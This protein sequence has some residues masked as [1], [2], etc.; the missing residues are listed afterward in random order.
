M[1]REPYVASV[2]INSCFRLQTQ[3]TGVSSVFSRSACSI[4]NR[5]REHWQDHWQDTTVLTAARIAGAVAV[6]KVLVYRKQIGWL[7]FSLKCHWDQNFG[8]PCFYIF[9]HSLWFLV[10]MPNFNLLRRLEVAFFGRFL[11]R[12]CGR[13]YLPLFRKLACEW[14]EVTSEA[15]LKP[16]AFTWLLPTGK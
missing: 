9:E 11:S 15:H 13:H 1:D 4:L 2:A 12:F 3:N 6:C 8:I 10:T 7:I 5:N 14:A 16:S